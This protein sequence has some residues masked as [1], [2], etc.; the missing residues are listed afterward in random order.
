MQTESIK[1]DSVG[2]TGW[3]VLVQY[4]LYFAALAAAIFYLIMS[5]LFPERLSEWVASINFAFE[6][7]KVYLVPFIVGAI[8]ARFVYKKY[9]MYPIFVCV[10]NPEK[11][12]SGWKFSR[13]Y[14]DRITKKN[15]YCN[16][17]PT[18]QGYT[19]FYALDYDSKE[20]VIDFGY[21]H[22]REISPGELFARRSSYKTFLESLHDSLVRVVQLT[23]APMIEG[24]KVAK[25]SVETNLKTV[26]SILGIN[27]Q[28]SIVTYDPERAAEDGG[29]DNVQ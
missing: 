26:C 18:A 12:N 11:G 4:K 9:I 24:L 14:F 1:S 21:I 17:L 16:P 10:E 15:G 22:S 2:K 23:D 8:A 25:G 7:Y 6:E 27:S 3:D 28:D 20:G 29:L 19:M 13:T 5:L